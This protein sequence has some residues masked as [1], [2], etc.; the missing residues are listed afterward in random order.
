V[1]RR[2]KISIILILAFYFSAFS[3]EGYKVISSSRS[4]LVIE[5][6][7]QVDTS[8]I[9]INN[10]S[11]VIV[12]LNEGFLP[13][14]ENWG[15]PAV[16]QTSITIGVPAKNGNNI[17]IL[18]SNYYVINGRIAPKPKV[19]KEDNM[20]VNDYEVSGNYGSFSNYNLV[21]LGSYGI[22]R[23]VPTNTIMLSPVQ[24]YPAR[25]EIRIYK[26]I[27]FEVNFSPNQI[28]TNN[29]TDNFLSSML[30]NYNVAKNW[31]EAS[32]VKGSLKKTKG[33]FN[34]VLATG[35]WYRF[36][37]PQEGIYK[38]TKSMLANYGIDA[39]TV[40]PRTIKIYNNGGKT[41]PEN[42]D[43]TRPVDLVQNAITVVGEDDGK[44]DDGDYIL[45]YGH[46]TDFWAYDSTQGAVKRSFDVYSNHNYYWITSGGANGKRIQSEP[47]L[48]QSNAYNQTYTDAYVD[49][50]SDKINL[51]ESG[52]IFLGDGFNI[53]T[54]SRT[55]TNKLDNRLAQYPINYH[56]RVVNASAETVGIDVFENSTDMVSTYIGGTADLDGYTDGVALERYTSYN[57]NL[58]DNRSLLKFQ[59]TFGSS[60]DQ[61]YL[62]YFEINYKKSLDAVSDFLEFFSK[63]TSAAI[64]YDLNDFSSTDIQVFD[65]TDY[66]NVKEI[67]NPIILSGGE[68]KFQAQQSSGSVSKYIAIGNG[69]YYTPSNPTQISNQNIHGITGGAKF[70]IITNKAFEDQADRLR[71]YRNNQAKIKISTIVVDVDQIYNE[72]SCG[73]IDVTGIRDFVKYAYDNWDIKPEYVLLFG[74]GNYDYKDIEGKNNNFIPTYETNSLDEIYSYPMDDYYVMVDGDDYQ[75]D[76]AIG[77]ITCQ[78]DDEAKDVVDK[79]ISYENSTDK[80]TW[81][82]LITLVAD[83]AMTTD[84]PEPNIHTPQSETLANDYIPKSYDLDKIYLAEYPTVIT[85]AGRTKPAV[86]QAIID[87]INQG[88]IIVNFIGHGDPSEWCH[89][90]VWENSTTIPQLHNSR[91]FFLT[92]A[93]C[94]FGHF[95]LSS[96]QS[97]AEILLAKEGSGSI[98]AFCS[99]RAVYS[100]SN[101]ALNQLF[102]TYLLNSARDT[103][104]LPIPIGEAYF[105]AK[106]HGSGDIQNDEK[107]CLLG[108]PTL[109][110]DIPEYYAQISS[111]DSTTLTPN[112]NVQVK[113]LSNTKIEGDILKSDSTKWTSFNGQ[114][115]LTMFDSQRSVVLDQLPPPLNVITVP[116]GII[117]RGR[118]S[119]TNGNFSTDFVVPKDISYQNQN[120]K[121]NIYFYN[122]SSDGIG[123]SNQII[124]GGTDSTAVNDGKGPVMSIY[125]DKKN[126]ENSYMVTPNSTL[127]VDISDGTG[128]NT[129]GNGVGHDLEGILNGNKSNPIDF[130]NY[131]IGDVD[132]GGKSGEIVY[133]LSDFDPGDYTIQ[134]TAW[135]VYN[136]STTVEKDFTV[137]S[138]DEL[139]I[140]DVYNYPDPFV[141]ST[142]FTF[143]QNLD[144]PINLMISIYTIAG[145]KIK[146]IKENNVDEKFV[147]VPWDGRDQYGD[148]LANGVYLYKLTVKTTDGKYTKSELGKLAI[149]R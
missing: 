54:V 101:A 121:I 116:G 73:S 81:R 20:P 112:I 87:A 126:D 120:G 67:T 15:T 24:F 131:F 10:E 132:A 90:R 105:Y 70:I 17:R 82:N 9:K 55:Y 85:G 66:S 63:D 128:I 4:S 106:V 79:I 49:N 18:N 65:V 39:S 60:S 69:N 38:I 72:F 30:P 40:D 103:L 43:S 7:P 136:N 57:G 83:D 5:Y 14:P 12:R 1:L 138:N 117:Y 78:T 93:T 91:L 52:N 27:T 130:T 99:T 95:D 74:D 110:L 11:Y 16:P 23:G 141:S 32:T 107:F 89:E 102:Y 77:R 35:T 33:T 48:N 97:G 129:T 98:G 135:D 113:A 100:T 140:K 37:C 145:R 59:F 36:D 96:T 86:N 80:D 44:F 137:V 62:D 68:F 144:T 21:S 29:Q 13:K 149:I 127:Y 124:V 108:D 147:T 51:M 133:P 3:Q 41:P 71:D 109:R 26:M 134:V 75:D 50:D 143:Q 118:V 53:N 92:A 8:I 58:P 88:T 64:Q 2:S 61:A 56:F 111:V 47:S 84:G 76:L 122:S 45:F 19:H 119:I 31:S 25:N 148:I 28:I 104:N 115:I 125:F 34:S 146:E 123:Y 22:M 142:T 94:D 114:G 139:V 46:G 6:T 42:P